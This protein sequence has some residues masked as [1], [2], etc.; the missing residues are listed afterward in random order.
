MKKII[1]F[2]ALYVFTS[3]ILAQTGTFDITT[4]TAPKGWKKEAKESTI[5]FEKEDAAKGTYCLITIYKSVPGTADPKENFNMAWASLVKERVTVSVEPTMQP[6]DKENGWDV[7]SG[8]ASFEND[9][10]KGVVVLATSTG[11]G[12]MAN[13]I[14]L[15]NTDIYEK[16]MTAFLGS[17]HLKRLKTAPIEQKENK[18]PIPVVNNNS[19]IVG[20]W[21]KSGSVN[22]AYGNAAATGNSGYS[23]DQYTFN[24]NGTYTFISKTFRYSYD[25][26]LLVKENGTYTINGT[27]LSINPQKSILEAWSKKNGTDNWGTLLRT[28]VRALEKITYQFTKHYFSGIQVWNLVLQHATP[29]QRDGPFSRNDS[30]NNAWYFSPLSENNTAIELPRK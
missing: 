24:S 7:Q 4:Y 12:K 14:V 15:T 1:L 5:Q 23:K 26:L 20:T 19:P 22:P 13:I 30:F 16:E 8:Y 27:D 29:T 25:Q 18:T 9:G 21:G 6:A 28:Q 2:L 17:V 10:N 11:F 3:N